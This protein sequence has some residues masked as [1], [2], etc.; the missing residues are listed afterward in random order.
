MN[1][2]DETLRTMDAAEEVTGEQQ[3]R[4]ADTLERILATEPDRPRRSR[5]RLVLVAAAVAVLAG[6]LTQLP[7]GD[8]AYASWTPAPT[9]LTEA[10]IAVIGPECREALRDMD[11]ARLALAERRGDFAILLYR[12][13]NPDMSGSCLVRNVPGSDDVDDV[14]A[15]TGGGSGPAQVV[16]GSGFT[17]G[18]IADFRGASITDGAVGPDVTGVT[19]H[20]GKLTAQ[21]TVSD[22][23]YVV[24][25][26]GPAFTRN[27][28]GDPTVMITYDLTLRNGTIVADAQPTRPS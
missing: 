22:G 5:T 28:D 19:V 18:A 25:W 2:I 24:W 12:T 11:E 23:R 9:A 4:A 14:M 10:E 1:S 8:R 21:A 27:D 16:S 3:H 17:Q 26:P 13:E 7:D 15:G 20:A 6:G